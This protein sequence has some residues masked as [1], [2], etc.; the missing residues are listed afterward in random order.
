[1]N[2]Q[3]SESHRRVLQGTSIFDPVFDY[4]ENSYIIMSL[5]KKCDSVAQQLEEKIV[6]NSTIFII[7]TFYFS[8]T[9]KA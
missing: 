3:N 1:M 6:S 9:G 5:L 7:L 2:S 8:T 4:S